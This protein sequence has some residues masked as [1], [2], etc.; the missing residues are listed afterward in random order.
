LLYL[1]SWAFIGLVRKR[2]KGKCS[3]WLGL[4]FSA[5]P[6]KKRAVFSLAG[7]FSLFFLVFPRFFL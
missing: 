6:F 5:P 4:S 3:K 2:N 1:F 7:C